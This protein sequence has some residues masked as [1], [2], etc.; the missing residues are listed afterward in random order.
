MLSHEEVRA[1]LSARVD[2]EET[3]ID[4]AVVDAHVAQCPQCRAFYR[5]AAALARSFDVPE[6]GL[7][8]PEDL[9]AAIL[10]GV[11]DGWRAFAQRRFVFLTLGRVALA[12]CALLWV[13]WGIALIDDPGAASV[14][15]GVACALVFAAYRP[16]QIPGIA[17]VVGTMFTFTVGFVVRDAVLGVAPVSTAYVAVLVP[18]LLALLGTLA[19][20]RGASLTRAWRLLGAEPSAS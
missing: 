1:A 7:V 8:P 15:F 16:A 10:A 5:E 2:G 17:L 18:T 6:R 11:E 4:D 12:A 9:S 3:G 19:V 13:V 14:R 20:D